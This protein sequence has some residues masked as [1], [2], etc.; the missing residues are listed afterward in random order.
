MNQKIAIKTDHYDRTETGRFCED[1]F[2]SAREKG[3][4][5]MTLWNAEVIFWEKVISLT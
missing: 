3:W 5:L 4:K 2:P 1:P